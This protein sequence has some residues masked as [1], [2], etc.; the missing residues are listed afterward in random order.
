MNLKRE[1][2][3]CGSRRIRPY[4]LSF[5]PGMHN[6][7]ASCPD[8]GIYFA[9]PMKTESEL[10]AYYASQYYEQ[11]G[12]PGDLEFRNRLCAAQNQ[13][14]REIVSF[15]PPP[16]CFL[17]IGCGYGAVLGAAR[18]I[19]Y[20]TIGIEPGDNARLYA[21]EKGFTV[22]SESLEQCNF[23]DASFDVIYS[24][25]VI[26]HVPDMTRFLNEV[27]RILKPG[28]L[29]FF[30]TENYRCLHNR[31]SRAL[32]LLTGS[33]PAL[34]TADEHTFLFTLRSVNQIFPKFGFNVLSVKA[35]H[36]R[37]KAEKF[38]APARHGPMFKRAVHMSVLGVVYGLSVALPGLGAHLMASVMRGE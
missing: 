28:G 31:Y 9:N 1:C 12:G 24:W 13:L 32:H 37:H 18:A 15:R 14:K 23:E 5:G 25:H 3:I 11:A 4:A 22:R 21:Q 30:G 26:E 20:E 10:N 16:G 36:P 35:F 7:I 17:E 2:N 27:H 6:S 33:L 38:F 29:F 19:G 8:C 34:D